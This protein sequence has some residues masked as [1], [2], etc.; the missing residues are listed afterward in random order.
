[1]DHALRPRGRPRRGTKTPTPTPTPSP[2]PS[3][4]PSPTSSDDLAAELAP[5]MLLN[6][7]ATATP[8]QNSPAAA[9]AAAAPAALTKAPHLANLATGAADAAAKQESVSGDCSVPV[10]LGVYASIPS[11]RLRLSI[12]SSSDPSDH[13]EQSLSWLFHTINCLPGP[14]VVHLK[15]QA[16][17]YSWSW[18]LCLP[19]NTATF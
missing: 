18:C 10:R 12:A 7:R 15:G 17:S 9:A 11:P 8:S 19:K 6:P 5:G 1:V 14:P 16:A 4:P 13:C 3:P 2:S